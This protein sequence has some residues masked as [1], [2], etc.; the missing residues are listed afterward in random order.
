MEP[1]TLVILSI[2]CSCVLATA[3]ITNLVTNKASFREAILSSIV[4]LFLTALFFVTAIGVVG[5]DRVRNGLPRTEISAGE[6]AVAFIYQDG[7]DISLGLSMINEETTGANMER[8]LRLYQFKKDAF[9]GEI[10]NDAKNLVV[11][12]TGTFKKL[13]LE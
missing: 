1:L 7:V 8:R 12:E 5:P 3:G 13:R 9:E 11:I 2:V 10:K 4:G 6:F